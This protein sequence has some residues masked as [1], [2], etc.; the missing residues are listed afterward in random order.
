M[1][2]PWLTV[3][4]SEYE[5][6][7]SSVEVQQLSVL[8]DLF[9][10]AL[11]RCHPASIAVLGI[12]GGNGLAQVDSGIT[13]RIVGLDLN[14][15][16]LETVKQRYSHLAG[17]E[18]HCVDLSEQHVEL[19]PVQLVHAAL[20]FEHAG[21]DRCLENAIS[22]I[23]PGGNLS[24]VLQLPTKSGQAVGVSQFSS[25]QDLKSHF[26][27]VSPTWLRESL[28][29]RGLREIYQ[30]VRALPAGKGFW[31]GIFSAPEAYQRK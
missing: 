20:V 13:T 8:S 7:M 15:Q 30:A 23:A 4:L 21:V 26:S 12:A 25:I 31:I 16:Y 22:M 9:V 29:A 2:N 19:E 3:A 5:Q 18:L 27:L 10:E 6:H 24:V 1:P 17:L 14:P 11:R 28:A